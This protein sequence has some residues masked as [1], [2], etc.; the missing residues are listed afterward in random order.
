MLACKKAHIVLG[1][2]NSCLDSF[3][4]YSYVKKILWPW[5]NQPLDITMSR[6][7]GLSLGKRL[8][9]KRIRD[10]FRKFMSLLSVGYQTLWDEKCLKAVKKFGPLGGH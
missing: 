5:K 10:C 2:P 9:V 6:D 8:R 3:T 7:K 1:G 4:K